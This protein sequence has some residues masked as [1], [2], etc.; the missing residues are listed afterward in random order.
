MESA[1]TVL[2]PDF[3][4]VGGDSKHD[5][6]GIFVIFCGYFLSLTAFIILFVQTTDRVLSRYVQYCQPTVFFF[7][8]FLQPLY[9]KWDYEI[10][11]SVKAWTGEWFDQLYR[12]NS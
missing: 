3:L 6:C 8:D 9:C 4:N 10:S 12:L 2:S 1:V 7:T 11:A 5:V